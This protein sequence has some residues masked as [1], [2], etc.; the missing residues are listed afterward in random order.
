[1]VLMNIFPY[2][3]GH[4]EVVPIKHYQDIN[5]IGPEEIKKLFCLV[6]RTISLVKEAIRPDGINVGLN[7]GK[8]AG[9]SI[10]HIHIHIVPRFELES[11]FMETT[12]NTRIIDEDI[13]VTYAKFI[14]KLDIL[15]EDHEV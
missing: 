4:L 1:M 3:R 11:G 9:A 12:A 2:N 5:E 8:A 10:E 6:Q 15:R 7:L 13:N 14:E